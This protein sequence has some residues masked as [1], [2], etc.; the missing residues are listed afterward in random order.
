M[1]CDIGIRFCLYEVDG[2]KIFLEINLGDFFDNLMFKS[3]AFAVSMCGV[4]EAVDCMKSHSAPGPDMLP[5]I[6]SKNMRH[7]M[8]PYCINFC[9][10]VGSIS[11]ILK[12]LIIVPI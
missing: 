12:A 4:A 5:V 6:F 9:L 8:S 7:Y 2:Q 3:V 10:S 1:T 11:Q